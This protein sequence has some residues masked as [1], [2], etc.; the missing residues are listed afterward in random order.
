MKISKAIQ[1]GI[2]NI[3]LIVF[4]SVQLTAQDFPLEVQETFY[5]NIQQ[6]MHGVTFYPDITSNDFDITLPTC[7]GGDAAYIVNAYFIWQQRF[8]DAS[9]NIG[10]IPTFDP[11]LDVVVGSNPSLIVQ[12]DSDWTAINPSTLSRS[13]HLYTGYADVTSTIGPLLMS[14][15]NTI[16]ISGFDQPIG[17]GDLTENWGIGLV[18][19]YE[20]P[21]YPEVTIQ[22]SAGSDFFFCGA[23]GIA[24]EYSHVNCFEFPMPLTTDVSANLRGMFG[25]SA[26]ADAPYRG[27]NICYLTGSGALPGNSGSNVAPS[28]D[29]VTDPNAICSINPTWTSSLGQEWDEFNVPITIPTGSSWVCLQSH[30]VEDPG[31]TAACGSLAAATYSIDYDADV[32]LSSVSPCVSPGC[33]PV[34]S[35]EVCSDGSDSVTLSCDSG[36]SD[37][38]WFDADGN[39]VGTGCSITLDN[40]DI[41]TG[42]VGQSQ[43]FYYE[44]E[45]VDGCPFVSCCPVT[46]SVISCT[47]IIPCPDPNCFNISVQQN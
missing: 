46:V 44:A 12:A 24:G 13:L 16:S 40:T 32:F 14:G 31:N 23:D 37:V 39:E 45:D 22:T 15:V 9:N 11:N 25:G 21:E 35:T 43:C 29:L 28:G 38:I 5:G 20:C 17:S 26:N 30:S 2:I 34:P 42:A 27:G 47:V 19:I 10:V 7:S 41:Q 1:F 18:I 8:R 4:W 6:D 3:F 36:M 33:D